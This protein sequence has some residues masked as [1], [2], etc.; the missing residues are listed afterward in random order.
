MIKKRIFKPAVGIVLFSFV[1]VLC[2]AQKIIPLYQGQIPNAR[3]SSD[4]EYSNSDH[5]AVFKVSQPTVSIYLPPEEK[6]TGCAV[7]ICPGGGY[8]ALVI[9][10]EGYD[11]AKRFVKWGIAAIVLKYRL[12]E[13]RTMYDKSIGPI[14]DAQQAIKMVRTHAKAWHVDPGKIG[15]VGFSAG[16]HLA[17]TAGTHFLHPFIKDEEKISLRP[18]FMI[19]VYPVI[20]MTD[21]LGH[22]GS[23]DN[24]LGKK[25][26]ADAVIAFSNEMQVTDQT[27]P[28]FLVQAEDDSVVKVENSVQF[29]EALRRHKVPVTLHIYQRG[30]H[31]FLKYPPRDLWMKDLAYWMRTNHWIK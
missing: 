29:Y 18:D 25:P 13:D 22:S 8:H 12:P 20:S 19:L 23:R 9:G 26:D 30:G 1:T 7:I 14:Q 16:G 3:F 4:E 31:G 21:S 27:P 10:R 24:L 17:S 11:M 2:S 28:A 6:S 15:I 5:S